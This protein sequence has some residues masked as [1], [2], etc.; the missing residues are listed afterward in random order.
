VA[1]A[2]SITVRWDVALDLN[3]PRYFLY[4]QTAPFDF[5]QDP[6]LSSARRVELRPSVGKGYERGG[7]PDVFPYEARIGGLQSGVPYY[8]VIRAANASHEDSNQAVLS[9]TPR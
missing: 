1:G 7:G 8:L 2:G 5:L 6:A 3:P 4:L 9:A